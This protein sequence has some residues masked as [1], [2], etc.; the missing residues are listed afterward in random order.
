MNIPLAQAASDPADP[1]L[2][3]SI[4]GLFPTGVVVVSARTAE[5]DAALTLQSFQSL[6]LDPQLIL[7]SVAKTSTSWPAVQALGTFGVTFLA[8]HQGEL[9]RQFS[10]SAAPDKFA[11]VE[12]VATPEHR[13]PLIA[14]GTAWL[15]CSIVHVYDGGDHAIVV[16]RVTSLG[17]FENTENP[18]LFFGSAFAE[19]RK[20]A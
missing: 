10:R 17:T 11:G 16:A 8:D 14:E 7:I 20:P 9:A 2:F 6:S 13:H 1:A 5:G 4:M 12:L 3:R 15:E 19:L 18:L